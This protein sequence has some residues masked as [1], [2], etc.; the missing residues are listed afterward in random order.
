MTL[1]VNRTV[2]PSAEATEYF[3]YRLDEQG[4]AYSSPAAPRV[5][6]CHVAST[7]EIQAAWPS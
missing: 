4:T 1:P 5:T 3:S 6:M 7:Y 2:R